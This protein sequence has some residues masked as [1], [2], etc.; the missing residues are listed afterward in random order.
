MTDTLLEL[1]RGL[2][3]RPE[4]DPVGTNAERLRRLAASLERRIQ[5]APDDVR[6]INRCVAAFD[7][8]ECA[9]LDHHARCGYP[10]CPSRGRPC[11]F[12]EGEKRFVMCDYYLG[13]RS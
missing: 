2:L 3:A 13:R 12:G 9:A 4:L 11:P 5:I 8:I 7:N 1:V 10:L 6:F